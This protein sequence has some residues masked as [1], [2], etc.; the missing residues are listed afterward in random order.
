MTVPALQMWLM[1]HQKMVRNLVWGGWKGVCCWSSQLAC[2][3]DR[4][5]RGQTGRWGHSKSEGRRG[6]GGWLRV[7]PGRVTFV[8]EM[9]SAAEAWAAPSLLPPLAVCRLGCGQWFVVT[10]RDSPISVE[11]TRTA[12]RDASVCWHGG[13]LVFLELLLSQAVETG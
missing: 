9:S 11:W 13:R 12:R 6:K 10:L 3:Q 8:P 7:E 2:V 4:R 1:Q 5:G